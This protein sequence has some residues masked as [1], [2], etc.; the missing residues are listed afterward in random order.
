MAKYHMQKSECE[1][2]DP[3]IIEEIITRG[4]FLTLALC[5]RDEPY[6]LTLDYGYDTVAHC[7]YF[8]SAKRGLKLD[9]LKENSAVCGTII[10][11]NG[12]NEKACTHAYRTLVFTGSIE[13]LKTLEEKKAGIEVMLKHLAEEPDTMR[14]RL[15]A[16][17]ETY[18][19]IVVLRL[20]IDE[21]TG[22]EGY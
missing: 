19:N 18:N 15:L 6:I 16:R 20:K 5:R 10:E 4:K 22:K 8:H 11:D 13:V 2:T 12:Y 9:I 1:I 14:K 7:M 21:I 3:D 17:G